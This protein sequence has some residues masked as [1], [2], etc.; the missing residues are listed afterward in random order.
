MLFEESWGCSFELLVYRAV[1]AGSAVRALGCH[2]TV[3]TRLCVGVPVVSLGSRRSPDKALS[4]FAPFPCLVC[5]VGD[6]WRLDRPMQRSVG[7]Y[8]LGIVAARGE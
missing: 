8:M 4:P 7:G 3:C 5:T 1:A 2:V 6:Q